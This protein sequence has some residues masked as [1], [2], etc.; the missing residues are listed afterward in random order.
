MWRG[1]QQ[2]WTKVIIQVCDFS[3]YTVPPFFSD[4]MTII[5]FSAG[6]TDLTGNQITKLVELALSLGHL[7]A[8]ENIPLK[9]TKS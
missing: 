6:S 2:K 3:T 5:L 9:N 8:L 4:S 7:E 1:S